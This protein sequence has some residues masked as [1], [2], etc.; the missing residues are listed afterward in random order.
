MQGLSILLPNHFHPFFLGH[1]SIAG[2]TN[3]LAAISSVSCIAVMSSIVPSDMIG[4]AYGAYSVSEGLGGVIADFTYG[5]LFVKTMKTSPIFYY[6]VSAG[7]C[8][9]ALFA[10]LINW[11]S[12][13]RK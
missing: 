9:I 13:R 10:Q 7:L 8:T 4:A 12:Y 6:Y 3:S 2:A 5:S 1:L 11:S